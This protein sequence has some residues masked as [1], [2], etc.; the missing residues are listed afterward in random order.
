MVGFDS[1]MTVKEFLRQLNHHS[2]M[3]VE[4]ESG[5]ALFADDPTGKPLTHCLPTS[6]K[7]KG[8]I[9][10]R[11]VPSILHLG[12]MDNA[13]Y[14]KNKGVDIWDHPDLFINPIIKKKVNAEGIWHFQIDMVNNYRHT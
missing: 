11:L 5:F 6:V 14:K 2:G 7:V 12:S 10:S 8:L 13:Y 4:E 9:H 1:S 3:R